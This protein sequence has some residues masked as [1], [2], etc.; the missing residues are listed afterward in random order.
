MLL[1]VFIVVQETLPHPDS[2]SVLGTSEASNYIG[3]QIFGQELDMLS[4]IEYDKS[5]LS[6]SA[7]FNT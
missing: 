6:H 7:V 4:E 5:D 2:R 3:N 1:H